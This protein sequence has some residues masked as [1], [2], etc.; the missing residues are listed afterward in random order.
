MV[1][2]TREVLA[3]RRSFVKRVLFVLFSIGGGFSAILVT[4]AGATE[5]HDG[6]IAYWP[7]DEGNGLVASDGFGD[8]LDNGSLRNDP[9]WLDSGE[10]QLGNSA[11]RFDGFEQDVLLRDSLDLDIGTNAVSLSAWVNMDFL[12]SELIEDFGGVF[13]SA[14]DNY[15]LY[16]DRGNAELRFKVTDSDGSA[17]RPGIPESMLDVEA[18]HHVLGV[19]N[20]EEGVAKIYLNGLLV[21]SHTNGDLNNLV[22]AGQIAGIGANP[23]VDPDNPSTYFF[24]GAVDDVAVWNRA[25]GRGEADYLYNAGNGNAVGAVNADIAF[26]SDMPPVEPVMPTVEPILHY[27]FDG[28]LDNSGTALSVLD[29]TLLDAPGLN[30]TIL[31]GGT[32]DLRE[33]PVSQATDGD[34]VSVDVEMPD[35]GTIVLDYTV[36]EYYN[37]QSL[38]TN[39]VD[40]N[41]WEMWIYN[42]GRVRGR[43]DGDGFVTFDLDTLAGLDETYQIAFTWEREDDNVSVKLFVDG[44][45]RDQ[46]AIGTWVDPGETLFIGGGDGTN[47][48]ANGVFD[49]FKL[50][51]TALSA[52]EVLYLFSGAGLEGDFDG[53]GMLDATD[54]DELAKAMGTAD[55]KFDLDGDG[56]VDFDD[57]STWVNTIKRTWYGDANLD[58]EFNS[59]DFVAAFVASKYETGENASWSEGDWN[60]DQVFDTSDFVTAFQAKGYENGPRTPAVNAV[61]EPSSIAMLLIGMMAVAGIRKRFLRGQA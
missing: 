39:S 30:D 24:P 22:R 21:D 4:N 27:A 17:E 7:L 51:D 58:G 50:Y 57:R 59:S 19:Y 46:D 16:L 54:L 60:G 43:V 29:G 53:N 34:A 20:G 36:G 47:H 12:P 28:N 32:L 37:F 33:N 15:I 56:D 23:T 11:L 3:M 61:P 49:D 26:L 52:G 41:D 38:F 44:E 18:W 5:L 42:D 1:Q 10:A 35:N 8:E 48:F 40:A 9:S 14:Q 25:L 6:L 55:P 45:M 2:A 13:D 31:D